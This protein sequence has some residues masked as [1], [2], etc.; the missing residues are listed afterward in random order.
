MARNTSYI[1]C[2]VVVV[3]KTSNRSNAQ[4]K[5]KIYNNRNIDEILDPKTKLPGIPE[6]AEWVELGI[7]KDFIE[8]YKQ[9]YSL[10]YL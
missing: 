7:G 10:Q 9:K 3:F 6:T 8:K 4:T 5:M 2:P 1:N